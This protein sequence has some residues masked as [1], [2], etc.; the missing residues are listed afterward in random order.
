[1]DDATNWTKSWR[2]SLAAW[3]FPSDAGLMCGEPFFRL[4]SRS[5]STGDDE[6]FL[7]P[8][9]K[10]SHGAEKGIATGHDGACTELD[11]AADFAYLIDDNRDMVC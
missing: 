11:P 6:E 5:K 2:P 10:H 7:C 3:G 4:G 1:M 8:R 9:L